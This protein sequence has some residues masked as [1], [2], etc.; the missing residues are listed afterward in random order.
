M[1]GAFPNR[2]RGR[3]KQIRVTAKSALLTS[4]ALIVTLLIIVI[5]FFVVFASRAI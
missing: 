1:M 5:L 4:G 3:G 2:I